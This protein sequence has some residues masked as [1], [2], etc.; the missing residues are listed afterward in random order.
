MRV[1]SKGQVTIPQDIRER[2]GFLPGTE[3]AFEIGEDG[4]VRIRRQV[5][6][7]EH[8]DFRAHLERMRGTGRAAGMTTDELMALL[9]GVNAASWS[10]RQGSGPVPTSWWMPTS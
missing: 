5:E 1:T 4:V 3:V 2:A 7:S 6:R 10:F 8:D 9:R